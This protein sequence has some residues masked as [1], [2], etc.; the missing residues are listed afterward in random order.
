MPPSG[1]LVSYALILITSTILYYADSANVDINSP[2]VQAP[3]SIISAPYLR[4]T[5]LPSNIPSILVTDMAI[6]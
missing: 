6:E 5:S 3:Q 4:Y 1:G 2:D